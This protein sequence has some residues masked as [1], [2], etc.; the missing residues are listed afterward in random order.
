MDPRIARTRRALQHAMLGLARERQLDQIT[1]ADV[2]ERAEVTRSSFYLH[3]AD[4]ETL[5]ADA[6]DVLAEEEGA[7]LPALLE[8]LEE[9]P[10]ALVAYL[11]HF[12]ANAELYGRVLGPH[13]SPV[14][15]ARLHARVERLAVDALAQT[16]TDAFTGVPADVAAAGL[17]GSV[18]GVLTAW[19]A[20]E[21]R[22]P[23][24]Q[25]ADWIWQVLIGPGG[26][27][28]AMA[29]ERRG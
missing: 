17:A 10:Q 27:W 7:E 16:E 28:Q 11:R 5:L 21:P 20:R 9:P 26:A 13:G 24:E 1:V 12:D 19:M 3:Y 8:M 15:V 22:P 29:D 2:V 18:M 6:L 25:G 4:R 23:V 14:A